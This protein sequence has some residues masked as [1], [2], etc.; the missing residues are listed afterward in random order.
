MTLR[1]EQVAEAWWGGLDRVLGGVFLNKAH[2]Y[3]FTNTN[4]AIHLAAGLGTLAKYTTACKSSVH[5]T[6]GVPIL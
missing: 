6:A 3:H 2:K 5:T 1:V 4:S